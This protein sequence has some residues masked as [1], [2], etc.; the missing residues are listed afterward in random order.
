MRTRRRL[1]CTPSME[2]LKV[3]ERL[4]KAGEMIGIQVL[5]H[6]IVGGDSHYSMEANGRM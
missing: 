1:Y 2:D 6:V 4:V 3:T 5:D